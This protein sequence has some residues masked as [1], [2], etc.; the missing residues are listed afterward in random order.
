[1]LLALITWKLSLALPFEMLEV[2]IVNWAT[3]SFLYNNVHSSPKID[4]CNDVNNDEMH[5][6]LF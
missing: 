1:M 4:I 5:S 2:I 6:M 3:I